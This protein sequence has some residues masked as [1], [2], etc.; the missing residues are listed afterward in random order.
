MGCGIHEVFVQLLENSNG[1][2]PF[3]GQKIGR[4]QV[5]FSRSILG[6]QVQASFEMID[7]QLVFPFSHVYFSKIVVEKVIL[8]VLLFSHEQ[9]SQR[10]GIISFGHISLTHTPVVLGLGDKFL[11]VRTG[12]KENKRKEKQN[13]V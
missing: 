5:V 3:P 4:S 7:G 13:N 6:A 12:G 11:F 10:F 9:V 1:L 2:I 8:A